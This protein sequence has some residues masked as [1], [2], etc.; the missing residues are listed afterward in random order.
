MPRRWYDGGMMTTPTFMENTFVGPIH[1]ATYACG[2]D[3]HEVRARARSAPPWIRRRI[4]ADRQ[5]RGM[6]PLWGDEEA[7]RRRTASKARRLRAYLEATR[8][9]LGLKGS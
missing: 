5:A 4:D 2:M 6:R 8:K 1:R 7:T 9:A 3:D